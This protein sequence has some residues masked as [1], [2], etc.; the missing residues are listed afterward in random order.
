MKMKKLL[1]LLIAPI[2]CLG[3][4][5]VTPER[6]YTMVDLHNRLTTKLLNV[7]TTSMTVY[8]EWPL[9]IEIPDGEFCLLGKLDIKERGWYEL[10]G[11]DVDKRQGKATFEVLYDKIFWTPPEYPE[12]AEDFKGFEKKAF[13]AIRIPGPPHTRL[14]A[15]CGMYEEDDETDVFDVTPLKADGEAT[16]A[17]VAEKDAPKAN[18]GETQVTSPNR[19][20][21]SGIKDPAVTV[22]DNEPEQQKEVNRLWLYLTLSF[23]VLC[24]AFYFL[25]KK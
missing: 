11:L 16:L 7:G 21:K 2:C 24:A 1:P 22:A 6:D 14:G 18:Q 20:E 10:E 19:E 12:Y 8:V 23:G 13:F 15:S 4:T 3:E 5:S 9:N 17:A 25:R